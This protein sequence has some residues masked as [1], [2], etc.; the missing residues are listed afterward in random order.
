VVLLEKAIAKYCGGYDMIIGGNPDWAVKVIAGDHLEAHFSF[1]NT[2][3]RFN[4]LLSLDS[5]RECDTT[6]LYEE[7]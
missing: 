5:R 1:F 7:G 6:S 2:Q 4:L 3:V